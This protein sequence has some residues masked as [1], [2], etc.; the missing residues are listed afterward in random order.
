[1]KTV[2]K[3]NFSCIV[4]AAGKGTRMRSTLPKVLHKI[5]GKPMVAHVLA[6]VAPLKPQQVV[7]VIAPQMETVQAAC[8]QEFP[9]CQFAEQAAQKGTGDAV[10]QGLKAMSKTDG[11]VLVVYGDTPLLHSET[12]RLLL[13]K[14]HEVGAAIALLGIHPEDPTGYGRLVMSREPFVDRIVEC[15]DASAQEKQI[16]WGWGGVMAFKASFLREALAKLKPSPVTGEYYLTSLIDM[17]SAQ[18][19]KTV[20]VPMPM[21]EAMGVNDCSQL[22]LAEAALQQRLRRHAMENGATLVDPTTVYFSADTV[23]GRDVTVHPFVVFGP[24]VTVADGVEIR[25][26]SHIEGAQIERGAIIGPFARLRPGTK[27]E[28]NSHVGNFV[29][30]KATRLG[31]GAKANHLSYIGDSDVGAGANIGAGTITCNYDGVNKYKTTIGEGAFIGSN[32]SLVAPVSVGAGAII[33]AG[34]VITDDVPDEALAL[35]RPQQ[36]SKP[37]KATQMRKIKKK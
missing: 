14:K 15:K 17:A 22:A 29:E 21:E 3:Y 11:D 37:G 27:L 8:W 28:E 26:Y 5:A 25:S 19:L 13:E 30:L 34:S 18:G 9:A 20:M 35:A 4:L 1:M 36:I 6:S 2:N 33:G 10:R 32:T 16:R 24:Q 7:T 31:K 12:L 23:L